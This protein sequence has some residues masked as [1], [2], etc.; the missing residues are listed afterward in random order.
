MRYLYYN[1]FSRDLEEGL[2]IRNNLDLGEKTEYLG[3]E[4]VFFSQFKRGYGYI[5][6]GIV[7]GVI[8]FLNWQFGSNI[9]TANLTIGLT[10]I[11]IFGKEVIRRR[12][13]NIAFEDGR[14]S[15][16]RVA[17]YWRL[18][19]AVSGGLLAAGLFASAVDA[20]ITQLSSLIALL[21]I[22]A[23]PFT[24]YWF[25]RTPIEMISGF[26]LMAGCISACR[27]QYSAFLHNHSDYLLLAIGLILL[28]TAEDYQYFEL[29][30]QHEEI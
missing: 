28:G 8:F 22:V 2:M 17:G 15:T 20:G 11:W 23:L 21:I 6:G 12:R 5:L 26:L 10:L 7:Y 3:S 14:D 25:L 19:I 13:Y 30:K 4:F 24:M 16:T 1:V 29:K 27:G 9:L 18:A